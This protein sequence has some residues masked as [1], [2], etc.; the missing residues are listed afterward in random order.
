MFLTLNNIRLFELNCYDFDGSVYFQI[1][2]LSIRRLV[3]NG[4]CTKLALNSH[5]PIRSASSWKFWSKN[6]DAANEIEEPLSEVDIYFKQQEENRK[7]AEADLIELKR[8]K[9][10]LSA[11]HR[12]ML[13]GEAPNVG[14][15]FQYTTY[16]T[17]QKFKS[18]MMN[19]HHLFHY[20]FPFFQYFFS[21]L[22]FLI[23]P[24]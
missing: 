16:H 4:P 19:K 20:I 11:S 21:N 17:G 10:R 13:R 6:K 8:N 12:Q 5:Q 22:K 14:L 18:E 9:S 1:S 24:L 15:R 3:N 23:L 2:M 7:A